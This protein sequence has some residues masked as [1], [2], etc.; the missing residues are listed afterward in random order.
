MGVKSETWHVEIVEKN[1]RQ[2]LLIR[3]V[4]VVFKFMEKSLA[5]TVFFCTI[6]P[7]IGNNCVNG[8]LVSRLR[9]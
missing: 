3:K 5:I 7:M 6:Y 9:G 1:R 2:R 8:L 4:T